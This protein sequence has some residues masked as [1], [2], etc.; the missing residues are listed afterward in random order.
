MHGELADE[1][2]AEMLVSMRRRAKQRQDVTAFALFGIFYMI[3]FLLDVTEEWEYP[4]AALVSM[5]LIL[6]LFLKGVSRW[7]FF[8]FLVFST[9]HTLTFDFPDVGNHNNVMLLCN[10]FLMIGIIYAWLRPTAV[11][12][13]DDLFAIMKPPLRVTLSLVYFFAGFHKLN[14]DFFHPVEGCAINFFKGV[15]KMLHLPD[16]SLPP[17]VVLSA[18]VFVLAWELGGSILLWCRKFQAP[19]LLLCWVMHVFLAQMVFFDFSSLAFA[20]MLV[21]I[22]QAYWDLLKEKSIVHVGPIHLHRVTIYFGV[23]VL[24]AIAAGI[25]FWWYGYQRSFH[26][27]QGLALNVSFLIFI[28]PMVQQIFK[29]RQRIRWAGVSMWNRNVPWWWAVFPAFVLFFGLNPYL[30]LR[31]AGTF[32]MF[33][34]LRTEG[35]T[36]NHLLFG[37]NPLKWWNYQEDVVEIIAIDPRHAKNHRHSLAGYLLPVVEFKKKIYEWQ[38]KGVQ[39]LYAIFQYQNR[40]YETNDLMRENPWNVRGRDLEMVLLDFRVI[41]KSPIPNQCRW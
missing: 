19:V 39:D 33:S 34:N 12:G 30:G 18:P 7:S 10:F 35:N 29:G 36:A 6:V 3:A 15:L 1:E 21:F 14:W 20:L 31:T 26:R 8:V 40:V 25:Y 9:I 38:R 24:L 4:G 2:Q 28:W 27:W 32:T 17:F 11:P 37:S 16:I 22:P 23:N 5:I 13:D 41:Q